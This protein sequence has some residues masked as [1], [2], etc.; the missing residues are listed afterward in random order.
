M[1]AGPAYAAFQEQQLGQL[2]TG[3]YA[4]F[5]VLALDP[6]VIP[7]EQLRTMAVTMTVVGGEITFE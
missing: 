7:P 5:T 6:R 3:R 4:D 1:S 2:A